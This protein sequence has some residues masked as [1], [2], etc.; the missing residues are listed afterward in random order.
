[1]PPN[2][3]VLSLQLGNRAAERKMD[4]EKKIPVGTKEAGRVALRR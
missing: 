3:A 2:V 4:L 1:M